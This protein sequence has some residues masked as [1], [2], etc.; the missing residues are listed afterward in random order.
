MLMVVF[1]QFG[2]RQAKGAETVIILY[3]EYGFPPVEGVAGG[4]LP[5]HVLENDLLL[6]PDPVKGIS[7][8]PF[9]QQAVQ[10]QLPAEDTDHGREFERGWKILWK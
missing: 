3:F 8:F 4:G 6:L 1:E 9:P 5:V 2:H 10:A 7:R